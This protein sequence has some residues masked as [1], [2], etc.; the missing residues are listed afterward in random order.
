MQISS[1]KNNTNFG[2]LSIEP[3]AMK[4]ML[5]GIKHN[6]QANS[7]LPQCLCK[8]SLTTANHCMVEVN[9]KYITALEQLFKTVME[10]TQIAM[11]KYND[12]SVTIR[13]GI[14]DAIKITTSKDIIPKGEELG[15]SLILKKPSQYSNGEYISKIVEEL[16][17]MNQNP[18]YISP[19]IS[20]LS[21]VTTE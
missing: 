12:F 1:F 3:H 19:Y 7:H 11:K 2:K 4:Y 8:S 18:S 10:E 9:N 15:H 17:E 14:G 20:K 13:K 16:H 5:K 21:K 6:V